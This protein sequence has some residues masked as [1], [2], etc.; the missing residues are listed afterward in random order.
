[1]LLDFGSAP[2][3]EWLGAGAGF[4]LGLLL[5]RSARRVE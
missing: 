3:G 1:M 2:L 5:A 4:A